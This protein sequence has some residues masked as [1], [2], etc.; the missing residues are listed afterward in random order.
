LSFK[1][2]AGKVADFSEN[3]S[4]MAGFLVSGMY[5][6]DQKT[7]HNVSGFAKNQR[8]ILFFTFFSGRISQKRITP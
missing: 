5:R 1:E 2:Q 7:G 6:F 8:K 4:N 3:R